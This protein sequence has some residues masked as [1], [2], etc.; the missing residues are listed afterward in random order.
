MKIEKQVCTID[1]AKKLADLG[2][3][4][5]AFFKWVVTGNSTDLLISSSVENMESYSAFSV[6]ELG[7][8]LPSVIHLEDDDYYLHGSIGNREDEFYYIWF[9]SSFENV[10]WETFPAIEKDTEAEARA[11][12]LIW[13]LEN[14][15]L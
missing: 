2:V 7:V 11:E 13:L 3:K 4:Q 12:S 10:E 5:D 6:A 1:Q 14:K 9:L 15:Y 8:L